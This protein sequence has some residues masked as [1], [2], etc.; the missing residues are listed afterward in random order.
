MT[1]RSV[2]KN[3]IT[4]RKREIVRKSETSLDHTMTLSYSELNC[5]THNDNLIHSNISPDPVLPSLPVPCI[6]THSMPHATAGFSFSSVKS[7]TITP[8]CKSHH[9][10][11]LARYFHTLTGIAFPNTTPQTNS[12]FSKPEFRLCIGT[13]R[14]L[15]S[16]PFRVPKASLANRRRPN[17]ATIST[18]CKCSSTLLS[19]TQMHIPCQ[20]KPPFPR[21]SAPRESGMGMNQVSS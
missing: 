4:R 7:T 21:K 18:L 14:T 1:R 20:T 2:R 3:V 6:K 9:A 13:P 8:T 17:M 16:L 10:K 12:M 19:S 11:H 15:N 5:S